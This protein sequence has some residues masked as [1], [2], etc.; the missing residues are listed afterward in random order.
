[1]WATRA[2][3][4]AWIADVL[5]WGGG[6]SDAIVLRHAHRL[7]AGV[8]A[9]LADRLGDGLGNGAGLAG[10]SALAEAAQPSRER[11]GGDDGA[12]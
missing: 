8:G 10:L 7:G 5:Q 1:M 6:R 3:L 2:T 11:R 12:G 9:G 4:T